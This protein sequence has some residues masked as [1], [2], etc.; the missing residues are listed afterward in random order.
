MILKSTLLKLF[1]LFLNN[2]VPR[3]NK[4]LE[5]AQLNYTK[6]NH[7]ETIKYLLRF[8]HNDP[9]N[10]AAIHFLAIAYGDIGLTHEA[11][12]YFE[13][14]HHLSPHNYIYLASLARTLNTFNRTND[15]YNALQKSYILNPSFFQI[16]PYLGEIA[17]KQAQP[18]TAAMMQKYGWLADFDK[19]R[20]ANCYLF[21]LSHLDE[22]RTAIEHRFWSDTY[23]NNYLDLASNFKPIGKAHTTKKISIAYYSPDFRNHAV[24]YFFVPLL[25]AHDRNKFE[26]FLYSDV[27]IE[28]DDTKK[29]MGKCDKFYRVTEKNNREL[30]ELIRSNNH[31]AIIEMAGHSSENRIDL[32]KQ[33]M[34]RIQITGIGYP[35]TTGLDTMD[36]KLV[37]NH[38][39]HNEYSKFHVEKPLVLNESFWSFNPLLDVPDNVPP[40]QIKNGYI[41][42]G[43]FGSIAKITT[44]VLEAWS[45]ILNALPNAQLHFQIYIVNNEAALN[46]FKNLLASYNLDLER[47]QFLPIRAG[48]EYFTS[49]NSIDFVL[50]TYPFNGGTTTSSATYMGVPVITLTGQALQSRMGYT[51]LKNLNLD[52]FIATNIE[53]YIHIATNTVRQL[54]KIIEFRQ[55]SRVL[56]NKTGLGNAARFTEDL[57]TK[58]SDIIHNHNPQKVHAVPLLEPVEMVERMWLID[59]AQKYQHAKI[60]LDYCLHHYQSFIPAHL[61]KSHYLFKHEG[62]ESAIDYLLGIKDQYPSENLND[63]Y[64]QLAR[65]LLLQKNWS[66]AMQHLQSIRLTALNEQNQLLQYYLYS[67]SVKQHRNLGS[68]P[69]HNNAIL[70]N[71]KFCFVLSGHSL[72]DYKIACESITSMLNGDELNFFF[73]HACGNRICETYTEALQSDFDFVIIIKNNTEIY[74]PNFL[75]L[76][77]AALTC[78]AVIS[79]H[80]TTNDTMLHWRRHANHCRYG[81][82][83][84]D[85]EVSSYP[86]ELFSFLHNPRISSEPIKILDGHLL[87]INPSKVRHVDF[88]IDLQHAGTCLE[89][90]WTHLLSC[91]GIKLDVVH[92]LGVYMKDEQQLDHSNL[93]EALFNYA[94]RFENNLFN[95]ELKRSVIPSVLTENL[96]VS[97]RI[98]NAL[99]TLDISA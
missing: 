11:L 36:Y 57:E 43:F 54:D 12:K 23:L 74:N 72:D 59:A 64:L 47:I 81:S 9:N 13:L 3:N 65:Y 24:K 18:A 93:N 33:R 87:V 94:T 30:L 21:Y 34:A 41:T 83:T 56:F 27:Q 49:Y 68:L 50:D 67:E 91:S 52:A 15:A 2:I 53:E 46:D 45:K 98:E 70:K 1:R 35:P 25:E 31:D 90:Q 29:I 28:D 95:L 66:Q 89:E 51:I 8:L 48:V 92:G 86:F 42:F 5:K 26:I 63:V 78:A 76:A 85:S 82:F 96:R 39:Y 32:F 7:Q 62:I 69:A 73:V 58:I 38:I 61:Y 97:A 37:D 79:F 4:N 71:L 75:N 20:N 10:D 44:P 60:V 40:P 22:L 19:L 6:K 80:G 88:D 77:V 84:L 55:N 16:F 14:A 99:I 17:F